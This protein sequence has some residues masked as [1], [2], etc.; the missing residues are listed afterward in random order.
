[1]KYAILL[2]LLGLSQIALTVLYH[3]GVY[4]SFLVVWSG[5]AWIL[6]GIAYT[7]NAAWIFGKRP[8][9]EMNWL[10]VAA[11]SPFLLVTWLLWH[12]QRILSKEA[13]HN[14]IAPGIWLG[15]RCYKNELPPGVQTV[16]DLTSEFA[17]PHEIRRGRTYLCVPTLDA[18][19][20]SLTAFQSLLKS[21]SRSPEPVY[22]HCAKGHGRSAMV[23]I[24]VLMAKGIAPS[25][26]EAEQIVKQ[27]RPAIGISPAQQH[28]LES[29]SSTLSQPE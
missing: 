18:A 1:M 25:L 22:V 23:V 17:E 4:L 21:V 20:P 26:A 13:V 27:S 14:E 19:A 2:T 11:F 5:I 9:G 3:P 7:I 8:D 28:L 15:R 12:I 6:A 29:W 16:V 10:Y 24:A